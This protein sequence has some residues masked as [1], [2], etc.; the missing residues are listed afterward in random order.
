MCTQE[1]RESIIAEITVAFEGVPKP[2]PTM[3]AILQFGD[4]MTKEFLSEIAGMDWQD[5]LK[6]LERSVTETTRIDWA[7]I[8]YNHWAIMT[9]PA[10]VYYT[11]AL[12]IHALNPAAVD[13][14]DSMSQYLV[15]DTIVTPK[16]TDG[17]PQWPL[18]VDTYTQKQKR[19]YALAV[20]CM[21]D[22]DPDFF[23]TCEG[24]RDFYLKML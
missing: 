21:S 11:P 9:I 7:K 24:M 12:L 19:A 5:M 1:E 23:D 20:F 2:A 22:I 17:A 3:E 4:F 14:A 18:R 15:T 8:C 6:R 10:A 13:I 16:S